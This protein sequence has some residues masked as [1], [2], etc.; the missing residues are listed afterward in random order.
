MKM[1]LKT[2]TVELDGEQLT[3]T[4][5]S[6]LERFDFLDYC[7]D[8]PKP[9]QPAKPDEFSSEQE[10]EKYLEEMSKNIKQWQRIN[11]M[12]Q[13]RLVAYGYKDSGDDLEDRHQQIMG[14]MTPDQVKFLH[15]EIAKFS[16]IPL[17]EPVDETTGSDSESEEAQEPADP[18]G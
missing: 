4:Q 14:S 2:Q 1:F 10:K 8:L 18:K 5:L 11:F 13:S 16:G 12:G 7:T 9:E 3:I 6:G 15:D 17:P